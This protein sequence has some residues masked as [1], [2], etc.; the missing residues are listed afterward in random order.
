MKFIR[1]LAIIIL[2]PLAL[3]L[4]VYGCTMAHVAVLTH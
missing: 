1:T 2:S 4:G 3:C